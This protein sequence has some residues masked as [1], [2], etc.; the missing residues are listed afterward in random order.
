VRVNDK[1]FLGVI[2]LTR[3][4]TGRL[5]PAKVTPTGAGPR[6]PSVEQAPPRDALTVI[7]LVVL[8]AIAALT[9]R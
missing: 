6:P 2:L 5:H 7:G 1:V 4:G 9:S 3:Q 8:V